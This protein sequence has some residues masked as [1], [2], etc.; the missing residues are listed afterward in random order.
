L[1]ES[2]IRNIN[3]QI[4]VIQGD[5]NESWREIVKLKAE[6]DTLKIQYAQSIVFAYKNR[7]SYDFLNFI[8]SASSFNDALSRVEY[9]KSY[10]AYREERAEDIR[11]TQQLLQGKIDGLK[12]TRAEKDDVLK[13]QS[14][15]RAI[16]EDEKKEKDVVVH[17]LQSHEKELRREMAAKQKQDQKLEAAISAAVR[18][19]IREASR[20]N[21]EANK[22]AAA[23]EKP[24]IAKGSQPAE[25]N[26]P[27]TPATLNTV[28]APAKTVFTSDEDVHLSGDFLK[29]KGQMPWPVSGTVSMAF[30]LHEYIPGV[31]HFNIGVTIDTRPG[32]AVKAVF[33][34]VVENI[35]YIGDVSAVMIRHGKYFTTYSNL[36]TVSVT[37]GEKIHI[38]QIVGQVA[39]AGQLDFILSDEKGNNF[40]PERWLKR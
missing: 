18:R 3:A 10:R 1:R 37:K 40:D 38:S 4:D 25:A 5:M 28:K 23:A 30:G 17:Q 35:M 13:K 9:L 39:E 36:S 29:N 16:L 20:K 34:G 7:S 11:N 27:V 14:R 26:E 2:A 12:V 22:A 6:L 32:S 33:E 15:E 8:F 24:A 19:A 31:K 21:V